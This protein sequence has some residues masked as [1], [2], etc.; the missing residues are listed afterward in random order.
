MEWLKHI[1]K[2]KRLIIAAL[3]VTA[4]L[5]IT[6]IQLYLINPAGK[7]G[8]TQNQPSS[9]LFDKTLYDVNSPSSYAVVVN[10]G[11]RL[12]PSYQP[13]DLITPNVPLRFLSSSAEMKLRAA[14]ARDLEAMFLEAQNEGLELMLVSGYR[15]YSSQA[16]IYERNLRVDGP[17]K[18]DMT[19]A[20]PGYSE[21]QTGLA[22]DIGT[23]SRQCELETCFGDTAEGKWLAS[24]AHEHGFIIRYDRG[25]SSL[26]GYAFEP[27][28]LRYV[29]KELAAQ[30]KN[31]RQSMEE[32]FN[33]SAHGSYIKNPLQL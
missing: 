29:G 33:L 32:F 26:T 23:K 6:A 4:G 21:H 5:I 15:S 7:T 1:F 28:H 17:A 20:R 13:D 14:A 27:W 12:P 8:Q 25:K 31:N 22:V 18:T 10:K 3:C 19:S 30:L 11:R 9:K 16:A 2:I 24:S